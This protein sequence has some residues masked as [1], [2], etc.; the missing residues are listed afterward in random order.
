MD[1]GGV[2]AISVDER[3]APCALA[4][5]AGYQAWQE[6]LAKAKVGANAS[7]AACA[8]VR[9]DRRKQACYYAAM[10]GIRT[11]QAA[12]DA[13]IA[14]G[15]AAREAVRNVKDDGRN[16]AI[17]RARSAS[18]TAFATCGDDGGS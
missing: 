13:I 6:A 7:E 15:P 8:E 10:S 12:R 16:D 18:D 1:A 5:V 17:A 9:N 14:G 11:A 3:S 2:T 4:N